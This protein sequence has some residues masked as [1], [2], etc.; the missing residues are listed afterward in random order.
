MISPKL[1][2]TDVSSLSKQQQQSPLLLSQPINEPSLKKTT[3]SI[4]T[5][6]TELIINRDQNNQDQQNSNGNELLM[7]PITPVSNN[8]GPMSTSTTPLLA[9]NSIASNIS[10]VSDENTNNNNNHTSNGSS[11]S[12]LLSIPNKIFYNIC[13]KLPPNDLFALA[14]VCNK[15]KQLLS[16]GDS[17][18]K[19][20]EETWMISRQRFLRYLQMPPPVGMNEASYIILRQLDKG[21]QFCHERG[22]VRIYWEFRVRCCSFCLDK[23]TLRYI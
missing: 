15:F 16:F 12:L 7:T 20:M 3:P 9:N 5:S 2:K 19:D 6:P 4:I 17:N 13:R 22:F 21:C 18:N 10:I 14:S 23:R 8:N 11:D 1:S